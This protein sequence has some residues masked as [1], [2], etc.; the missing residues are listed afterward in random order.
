MLSLAKSLEYI[1]TNSDIEALI[2]ESQYIKKLRPRFN[3][4]MRDDKQYFYVGFT[5]EDFP[6]IF[7]THQ[8]Q[9]NKAA[10]G[11]FTDGNSIKTTLRLLRRV[12]P[13]CTCKQLHNNYC[14][15]YH[16]DKCPGFCC[17]KKPELRITNYELREY[18]KNIKAIKGILSGKREFLIKKFEKEM[19]IMGRGGKFEEV[20][21]LQN[22]IKKVK[23]VFENARILRNTN[24]AIL[25]TDSNRGNDVLLKQLAK[26]IRLEH[27]P[28]RIEAYDIANIQGQHAVG[29]MVVFENGEPAKNQYRKFKIYTKDTPDDTAMLREVLT[30]RLKHPEWP[31]P[32]LIVIDGGK[33]QLNAAIEV[34]RITNYELRTKIIALTKNEKHMGEKIFIAGKNASIPLS[35][36]PIT[37]KNFLLRL[38]SEAHRF[39][40]SYYRK[41]HKI[42]IK[43]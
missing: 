14:L 19:K 10:I 5:Q 8:P 32:D 4:V 24:F 30:R 6:K 28:H 33:G 3:I 17:L 38:D 7:L 37:V 27:L 2:L 35:H 40:I 26:T 23:N 21:E 34:L 18:Q 39:A 12:F 22:K 31:Y 20:Q 1:S 29:A 15:N 11:P 42:K 43:G 25:D 13:Y 9:N 16:I 41:L 36:L